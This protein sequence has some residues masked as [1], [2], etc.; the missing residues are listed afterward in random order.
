MISQIG[1]AFGILWFVA[2]FM[3]YTNAAI[4][5][6]IY[7]MTNEGFRHAIRRAFR[8]LC[9]SDSQ[10]TEQVAEIEAGA[11]PRALQPREAYHI[12]PCW[13]PIS[14]QRSESDVQ[15]CQRELVKL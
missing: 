5:P 13:R 4:N 6:I 11:E 7:G 9:A 1:E 10:G 12:E 2:H 3:I 8:C 14:V 15:V